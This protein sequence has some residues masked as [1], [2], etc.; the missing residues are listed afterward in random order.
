MAGNF[1]T[2]VFQTSS[3]SR[4][5]RFKW[6]SRLLA[7]FLVL[8]IIIIAITMTRVYTPSLPN[9][10]GAKEKEVLLDSS[11]WLF[12]KSKIGK[13]YGG[14][15]KYINEKEAYRAGAYPIPKR[16]RKKNGI[17]VQ[18]DSSFYSFK[19]FAAGIRAAFYVNWAPTSYTS[20]EQNISRLNMVF[21][22]WFFL[23]PNTD[24]L[25]VDIDQKALDIMN[26]AGVKIVPMLSNNINAVFRGDVVH[27][28]LEDP[29]KR[30]RLIQDILHTLDSLKLDGINIDFE[31]LQEKKNEVLVNFQQELYQKMHNRGLLVSQ[32][33]I[34]FNQ[35]Y[36]FSELSKYNDYIVVMAY[37]QYS[38]GTQ[39]GPICHQ[40]WIEGAIDDAARKIP[41]NKMILAL[42]GF[43]Y[44]W[45][46][47]D[48]NKVISA[49]SISYQDALTLALSFDGKIIF[50]NDSYN[51][52]FSYDDDNGATHQ[53]QFTDAATTFNSM[54]FAVESGLS[55][56]ALWRLGSE[57]SRM[58]DF[59]DHDM[60]KESLK[61]F[62]FH[63]F[64]TVKSF[65]LDET[66][67]YS[68][69]GEVLDV[70]GGPTSGKI[71]PELDT[72]ELLISEERYDSLPS[73]W[74]ARKYGT[75][76]KK[77]LVLTFDDGPDPVYTPQILDIL[78][79]EKVPGAFFL[80]GI[81]AENNIPLVKRIYNEG[82]EIGNHTFTHPNIAKV[83]RKRAVIEMDATRLLIEC[84]TG[85]STIL[86]RA[87]Y[88]ADFE[89]QK[90]E[91]LIPVAI[92]RQ[93]NY[94]DI[95]E[96][97]DPL[98][99]VP[100][101]PADSI[102][103]RVIR[104]KAE[105]T[106]ENLSGNII[107]LH[108][109]GGDG[110][111]ATVEALPQIIHYFKERGYTFTT[112]ADLLGKTKEDLMPSVPRGSGYYLLQLNYFVAVT[113]YLSSHLLASLFILFIILSLLRIL[114]MAVI[115]SK[116]HR[117]EKD[118]G[119]KP[120]WSAGAGDA[121]LVSIIVPAFNEEVNAVSSVQNLLMTDYPRYE[122][123][124]V[125]D[126][127]RDDTYRRVIQAF[128]NYP[129][130]RVFTKPNGGKASALNYGIMQSSAEF[131]ICIDADTKL[132]PDAI[133]KLV[134]HFGP[135]EYPNGKKVGAVAGNVKVGNKVNLLTRWQSI[136]YISSQ[137]FDRKAFAYVNAITVVPGAIGAFRKAAIEEAG[138]FT[139]DTLA[140][141][142]DLTIRL[143]RCNYLVQNEAAAIAL[144]ESPETLKMFIK[145]RFRWSFGVLQTFWKN[146]DM[147]FSTSNPSLG[148]IALPNILL[149]QYI[150]PAVIPLAD[151]L[152]L[153]GLLTGNAA[154]IGTYY[155]IFMLVDVA[156]A[157]LA[158]SFEK[159]NI[160]KLL[161]L[162]PQRL[163]WRWLMWYVLFK[164]FRRAIKGELQNWGVLKRT[165][166]VSMDN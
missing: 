85:H 157:I 44:N 125:D 138:G 24:Q 119:L 156:V 42:A 99:W 146:R 104:R 23:N 106:S 162:I 1:T 52:H 158:F 164:S 69:E 111:A 95:G 68:G 7:L 116:Q 32:D 155:L 60:S 92:A 56:V 117:W 127:S 46:M 27:R 126:G 47:D 10:L 36:N 45:K 62:D 71:R 84:I 35:D 140:E 33:V 133:S 139:T 30:E 28:I 61:N 122:I 88:N 20:L 153:V 73:K 120:F 112:I 124:F 141:D 18:A 66:P 110:R 38:E 15:R 11:G 75:K 16:F 25:S 148:W 3:S 17:I 135:I 41:S 103:A 82:H 129:Q 49:E 118:F 19:K 149:F 50:D 94:L 70:I 102:V 34:P 134:M 43:G 77:K 113:A 100:G 166:N 59:Y 86:F 74:V 29:K 57:D 121:P 37:D 22:E 128:K 78:N 160:T 114:F 98:D 144:T 83:S 108:D 21:P 130:V 93:K 81:N 91:E 31:E 96:S 26:K 109:A 165:G 163:V 147:L 101:T 48:N 2:Q 72:S 154:R 97:I 6:S 39:P 55:G 137:N 65:S 143:L 40:K 142:C 132:L 145:Q 53:V 152:M 4:W 115:A 54:R 12:N 8:G 76:D 14:F 63:L 90:A 13:Q 89:P 87:P 5:S 79:R 150:I 80:V 105:M 123:I 9:M 159:E 58:W 51:L 136:E 64:S 107:L 161:W 151:F 131:L 67:A